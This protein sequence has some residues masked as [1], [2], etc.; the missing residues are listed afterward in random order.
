LALRFRRREME[1]AMMPGREEIVF[2]GKMQAG[3]D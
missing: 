1:I 3:F 2:P